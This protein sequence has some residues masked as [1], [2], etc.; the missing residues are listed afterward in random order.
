M[1]YGKLP[2]VFLSAAAS[3][4]NG[5][6]NRVIAEYILEHLNEASMMGIRELALACNVSLSS[7]SR[8]CKEIG[9]ADFAELKE[10]LLSRDLSFEQ[11]PE[12]DAPTAESLGRA[13][14]ERIL[15]AARSVDPN[16]IAELC[17]D[18]HQS[19]NVA[20]F[21]LLKAAAAAI[22]LQSD[23]LMLGRQIYTNISYPQQLEY[24]SSASKDSLIILFSYTGSYFEYADL[25][26]PASPGKRPKI[27][28]ISGKDVKAPAFVDRLLVFRSDHS[29]LGHPYQLQFLGSLIAQEYAKRYQ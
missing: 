26:L 6:T 29:Q 27:W 28:M 1:I 24:I 13:I 14:S 9:L 22:D 18:I 16:L 8:F 4:K 7:I 15:T 10:L 3:E 11:L 20:A 12:T 25:K 5:S 23:L 19:G 21:G 2:V 17:E